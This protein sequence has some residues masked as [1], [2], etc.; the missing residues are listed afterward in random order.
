[1]Q[2]Y[3]SHKIVK[4][5]KCDSIERGPDATG[6]ITLRAND[7]ELYEVPK[8]IFGKGEPQLAF[9]IVEYEDG[10]ISWSPAEAFEKGYKAI[11]LPDKAE[12]YQP[13][14]EEIF[15]DFMHRLIYE[16]LTIEALL[17]EGLEKGFLSNPRLKAVANTEIEKGFIIA[18]HIAGR[19]IPVGNLMQSA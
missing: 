3:Q 18:R 4:A 6:V 8:N 15:A 12:P 2:T 14:E 5:V 1:M 17:Q 19:P 11:N 13:T 16:Q 9:Y 7:G 10:Y